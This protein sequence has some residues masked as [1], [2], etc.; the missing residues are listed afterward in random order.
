[1]S[2]EVETTLRGP[3]AYTLA[4]RVLDEMREAGVWPTPLNYELWLH[5]LGDPDGALGR[6]IR[7]FLF[8]LPFGALFAGFLRTFTVQWFKAHWIIQWV[9]GT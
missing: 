3:E 1:M 6:E 5:Y 8:L 2:G 9:L 4:M 7:G